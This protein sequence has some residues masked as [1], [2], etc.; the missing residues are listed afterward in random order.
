ML[1][2]IAATRL[3]T[4]RLARAYTTEP[5]GNGTIVW[6]VMVDRAVSL[7]V[8]LHNRLVNSTQGRSQDVYACQDTA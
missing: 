6:I 2:T 1:R 5:A 7:S 3:I 4:T 8:L